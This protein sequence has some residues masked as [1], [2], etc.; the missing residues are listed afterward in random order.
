MIEKLSPG[1]YTG[2]ANKVVSDITDDI[3]RKINELI[4]LVNT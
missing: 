4:E 2:T 1:H 3:S